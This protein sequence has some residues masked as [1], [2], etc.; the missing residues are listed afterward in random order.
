MWPYQ[1]DSSAL[2]YDCPYPLEAINMQ[3][4]YPV[5][6]VDCKEQKTQHQQHLANDR[7][8]YDSLFHP[9]TSGS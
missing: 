6:Q 3:P 1:S 2:I 8:N 9:S 4:D 7:C 5:Q